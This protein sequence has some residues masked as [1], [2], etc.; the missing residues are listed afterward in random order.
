[1]G[2]EKRGNRKLYYRVRRENGRL[3][4]TY[5]G[6]GEK[7]EAAARAAEDERQRRK[8]IQRV[9]RKLDQLD[10]ICNLVFEAW[11]YAAGYHRP[12]RGPWR[13]RRGTATRTA[14]NRNESTPADTGIDLA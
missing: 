9:E 14:E 4:K 1:M 2:L 13:K 11:M 3:V 6:S 8:A 12:K 10:A 5:V 7:A